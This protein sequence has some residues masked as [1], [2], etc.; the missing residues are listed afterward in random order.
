VNNIGSPGRLLAGPTLPQGSNPVRAF[1][2]VARIADMLLDPGAQFAYNGQVLRY[3]H[4]RFIYW[5]GGN[6][7]HHHQDLNRLA[8]AWTRPDTI[9]V[10]E[11]FWNAHARMADIVLPATSTL[12][13]ND[14]GH[15]TRDALLVAMKPLAPPPGVAR[16]DYDIFCDLA[17]RLGVLDTFSEGRDERAW[18][19]HLYEQSTRAMAASGVELPD[20]DTFCSGGGVR[21]PPNDR[22]VR[23]LEA[24]RQD[25]TANPLATPSGR[26]E[27]FSQRIDDFGT[28][29]CAGHPAW[30]EPAEW[31]GSAR[32]RRHPLHLLSDQPW[33]KL[34]SQLDHSSVSL[35]SKVA[36]REPVRLH[37]QDAASRGIRAGDVVRVFNDRGACLAGAV[38]DDGLHPGVVRLSTGAWWDP[39]SPG[40]PQS[41]DLHGN[42][43]TLTRDVGSS[44]LGQGC[45][46]QTCLVQIEKFLGDAP[47]VR[48]FSPP[49]FARL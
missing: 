16:N 19:V 30:F 12:E 10:H 31:L 46:A 11:Q 14:I 29:G 42:P 5:A 15:A 8:R 49:Q 25:P 45:T 47:P 6:P 2:P 27:L 3:P 24:F 38:I 39:Q 37:P 18:L 9:V 13:R 7:F 23:Q 41:L 22:P 1:I 28:E 43:N 35:S 34:H 21:L 48:V 36:G 32:A 17:R 20:F 26:I 33:T 44:E 40:D 4:I